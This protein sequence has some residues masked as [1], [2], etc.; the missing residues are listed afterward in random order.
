[1]LIKDVKKLSPRERFWYWCNERHS[2][3]VRRLNGKSKPWTDDQIL[4]NY[5]FTNPYRED[6]KVT[7]WFRD[8]VRKVF[9]VDNILFATVCFRWFNF[10]P[11]GRLLLK[12]KLLTNWDWKKAVR[13]LENEEKVFTGAFTISPAGSTE[14][15]LIRVSRDFIQPIWDDR[16]KLTKRLHDC[17]MEEAWSVLSKYPGL[18]G[19]GFMAYEAVCD[20]RYTKL[21]HPYD[22]NEWT[23]LGPGAIRGINRIL[24]RPVDSPKPLN[25]LGL[26]LDLL[27][28]S[29]EVMKG[30]RFEMRE[31]EHSLCEFFKYERAL[32]NTGHLKRRYNGAEQ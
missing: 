24:D 26:C 32:F 10:I 13:I 17:G 14:P 15:K 2:I 8:N 22:R 12:S 6:D 31:I 25:W 23:N 30:P 16:R 21:L 7:A 5:F 19:G 20:L 28:E 3:Y 29:R 11:T 4:Q 18:G 1:M 9:S 27:E